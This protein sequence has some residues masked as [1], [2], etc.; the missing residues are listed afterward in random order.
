MKFY[1]FNRQSWIGREPAFGVFLRRSCFIAVIASP[2]YGYKCQVYWTAVQT[3]RLSVDSRV[4][5]A[6]REDDSTGKESRGEQQTAQCHFA[7]HISQKSRN[8]RQ[9][10][11]HRS[12]QHINSVRRLLVTASVVPSSPILV[13]LMMEALRSSETSVLTR[14]TR[15]NIPEDA[16]LQHQSASEVYNSEQ[17]TKATATQED[18]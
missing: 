8:R 15:L 14:P 1:C 18:D 4:D 11:A 6:A 7:Q 5:V 9:R 12:D 13:T 10:T 16:I 2:L 3:L 17:K